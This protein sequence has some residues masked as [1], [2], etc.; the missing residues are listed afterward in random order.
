MAQLRLQTA[1]VLACVAA[2]AMAPVQAASKK[3]PVTGADGGSINALLV[4]RQYG[5][6]IQLLEVR[7]NAGDAVAQYK[8]GSIYRVGLGVPIDTDRATMWLGKAASNGNAAAASIL[9]LMAVEV[10]PTIKKTGG[11]A[12]QVTTSGQPASM[13]WLP[14]RAPNQP[15][16]LSLAAARNLPKV[17]DTLQH[18]QDK[19]FKAERDQAL[20]SASL[21]GSKDVATAML[22]SGA[23]PNIKNDRART[24]VMIAAA[25]GNGPL[26]RQLLNATPDLAV[27]D[28]TGL[29]A[30]GHAAANCDAESFKTLVDEGA[31]DDGSS[32]PALITV[33]KSCKN[34]A[35]FLPSIRGTMSS[36][37]DGDGRTAVWHAATLDDGAIVKATLATGGDP[38][39]A[40]AQGFTPLHAAAMMGRVEN[41]R[42]LMTLSKSVDVQSTFGVTPLMLAASAGCADCTQLL[43]GQSHDIDIKDG[44]GDTALLRA[45]RAQHM[46]TV[47]IL[48]QKGAN[49]NARSL[50]AETPAKLAKRLGGPIA[51]LFKAS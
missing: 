51:A 49:Q 29:T 6:A 48:L 12:S 3:K 20:L 4:K 10:P 15:G 19:M 22:E 35:A 45:V 42:L 7:A 1:L 32:A 11:S 47:K 39:I 40:D 16:W 9:K 27:V 44:A 28:A 50:G 41:V 23:N 43:A 26:L 25:S 38:A 36:A 5:S 31:K 33:L 21:A 13:D 34:I 2:L 18:S 37:R 30:L 17:I 14:A 24:P 46:D 8:L